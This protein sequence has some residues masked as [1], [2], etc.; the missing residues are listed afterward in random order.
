MTDSYPEFSNWKELPAWGLYVRHA[1]NLTLENVTLKA[2]EKDYRPAI[3]FDDVKGATLSGV[4]YDVP[5][6][7]RNFIQHQS[8][9]I[10]QK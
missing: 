10:T 3:V 4:I 7:R 8:T 9:R 1:S 2:K 5:G 6:K